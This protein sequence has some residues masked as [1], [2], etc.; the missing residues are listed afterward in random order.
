MVLLIS[1]NVAA[2]SRHVAAAWTIVG[3]HHAVVPCYTPPVTPVVIFSRYDLLAADRS[4]SIAVE[5]SD[6][7]GHHLLLRA[8][9]DN[10]TVPSFI[11]KSTRAAGV[12]RG[13][14]EHVSHGKGKLIGVHVL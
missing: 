2:M 8:S 9:T 7:H 10:S 5:P 13:S 14:R 6:D 12:N 3:Q 1:R 11:D 4:H